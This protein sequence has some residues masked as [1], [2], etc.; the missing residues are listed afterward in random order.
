MLK[1]IQADMKQAMKAGDK[2]QVSTLRML[3]AAIKNESINQ[4]RELS[5]EE[6]VTVINR[7]IKQR[8][9]AIAEF[10]KGGRD[11]LAAENEQEIAILER[12]LPEQLSDE[13]LAAIVRQ[14][15]KEVNA[16]SLRDMGK[17]MGRVMP[18]VKGKAD[19]T[20]VQAAV[21]EILQ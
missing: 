16:A 8:R 7:E 4:R 14:A 1:Q 6:T 11:D 3:I 5:E 12:Y 19:G 9:N 10:K 21:K 17:V 13:E 18:Q 15:V 2:K 20:R